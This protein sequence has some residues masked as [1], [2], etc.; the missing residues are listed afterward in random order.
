MLRAAAARGAKVVIGPFSC[1]A[2]VN[3]GILQGRFPVLLHDLVGVSGEEW[4]A[5]PD[6]PTPLAMS[7]IW[8]AAPLGEHVKEHDVRSP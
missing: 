6:E 5:L 1:V 4:Q 8:D 7:S 2:D 3:A